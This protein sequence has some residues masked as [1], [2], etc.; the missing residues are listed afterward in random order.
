M[1]LL[2]FLSLLNRIIPCPNL[3]HFIWK[4]GVLL[5]QFIIF[6]V[7]NDL[8]SRK[9]LLKWRICSELQGTVQNQCRR[10]HITHS[11]NSCWKLKKGDMT[12][13]FIY[14]KAEDILFD[15]VDLISYL[16]QWPTSFAF[17]KPTLNSNM[18]HLPF[19][20]FPRNCY[21]LKENLQR[22]IQ[23]SQRGIKSTGQNWTNW[24]NCNCS[25]LIGYI[26]LNRNIITQI[27]QIPNRFQ[28]FFIGNPFVSAKISPTMISIP[29]I[30]FWSY[31]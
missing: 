23:A 26:I 21:L 13:A 5:S 28:P 14:S 3:S 31:A 30:F 17:N 22:G 12:T 25:P 27:F 10:F 18:M 16:F 2:H 4:N 19:V 24:W 11:T 15:T 9:S 8:L 29:K 20:C 6:S 7:M 1:I